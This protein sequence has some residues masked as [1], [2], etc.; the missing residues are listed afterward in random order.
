M[1]EAKSKLRLTQ[2]SKAWLE[3]KSS[4]NSGK[5]P[6]KSSETLAK[7]T[8]TLSKKQKAFKTNN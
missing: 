1:L 5:T 6:A 2:D 8:N 3:A 4:N 7:T